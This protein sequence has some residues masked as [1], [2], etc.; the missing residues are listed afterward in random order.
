MINRI[1]TGCLIIFQLFFLI[2][3]VNARTTGFH[4]D[5]L[6]TL[7]DAAIS[8]YDQ[9]R[10]GDTLYIHAGKRDF[11]L[12]RNFHGA[13]N[14]PIVVINHGGEVRIDTDH[15]F[16]ISIQN[17]RFFRFTG[18]GDEALHYGFRIS[19]V[20][21]GA[22]LGIGGLSSDIEIDHIAIENCK[23][24]GIY[25][26]TDPDCS[27]QGVR[28]RFTQYNTLIH[29][30]Y[31]HSAGNEG[32]YVG[33]AKF[34]GQWVTCNGKDTLLMPSLL[35]GVRI[36]N[37]I[38]V[39]AGKSFYPDDPTK[40]KHGIFVS[41]IRNSAFSILFNT[42]I[43]P[44]SDGIRFSSAKSRNN[45]V[46]SNVIINPGAYDYYEN[47]NTS[48]DGEDA[49]VMITD[50]LTEL[51]LENNYF[52]RST[53]NVGF[54]DS[55]YVLT[56]SSVLIDAGSSKNRDVD[57]DFYHD[58]RPYGKGF[59]IG[60]FE[61][62]PDFL[63]IEEI[64]SGNLSVTIF[65]VPASNYLTFHLKADEP[66]KMNVTIFNATGRIMMEER[67]EV[68]NIGSNAFV[69]DLSHFPEGIYF[70]RVQLGGEY[71]TGKFLKL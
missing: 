1:Q 47:G 4:V 28:G 43:N 33:S 63:R 22:G 39:D 67:K 54:A 3:M 61:F 17:C 49:Y 35:E 34:F 2:G 13:E 10:P 71:S 23:I 70:Y 8:P 46:Y 48:F 45:A 26:K 6:T 64:Q 7:V 11:L 55:G 12:I 65:P 56:A 44:K 68:S 36:Y 32:L 62:N 51:F 42:I 15:H 59:D 18:T 5:S 14:L 50:K 27:L 52:A 19:R 69:A 40:M 57:F 16:G 31:I 66:G 30:N 21:A 38:I 29:D 58:S 20:S 25:A 41:A 37:N 53:D 24:G 9:V 60:A